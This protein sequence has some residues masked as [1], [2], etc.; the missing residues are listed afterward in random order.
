MLVPETRH[1]VVHLHGGEFV[2]RHDDAFSQITSTWKVIDNVLR[3]R[4]E[5]IIAFDNLHLCR[6]P[7]LQF[8]LLRIVEIFVFQNLVELVAQVLVLDQDLRH[9]LL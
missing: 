4:F 9:S 5:T 1:F 6:E 7:L 2:E 3:Y 8:L